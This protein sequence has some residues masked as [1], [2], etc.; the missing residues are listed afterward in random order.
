YKLRILEEADNGTQIGQVGSLLRREGL[1]SSHLTTWRR[2]RAKGQFE[3]LSPK[4]RGRKSPE[5][6]TL[7]K[8]LAALQLATAC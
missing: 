8:E 1:Y 4:K 2:Q 3:G 6:N 5:Q 7:A